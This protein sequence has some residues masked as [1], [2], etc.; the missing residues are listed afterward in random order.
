MLQEAHLQVMRNK[1]IRS[2]EPGKSPR[3]VAMI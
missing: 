1:A 3:D 2:A